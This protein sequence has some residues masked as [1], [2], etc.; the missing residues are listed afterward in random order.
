MEVEFDKRTTLGARQTFPRL[1]QYDAIM[2][3]AMARSVC[4]QM[5]QDLVQIVPQLSDYTCPV[6]LAI[7]WR[8]IRMQCKHVL[9]VRCT[10]FMQRRGTNACPLCRDD[11]ILK[12]DQGMP[13]LLE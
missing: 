2:T 6:C 3:E 8:P 9:C 12:A 4:A 13:I 10:V 1:I 5:T 11:V 7:V